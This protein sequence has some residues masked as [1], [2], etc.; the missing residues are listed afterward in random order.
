VPHQIGQGITREKLSRAVQ[1][2]GLTVFAVA[3]RNVVVDVRLE[4]ESNR[5][6]VTDMG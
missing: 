2:V 4:T 6:Q 3:P 5:G 1:W